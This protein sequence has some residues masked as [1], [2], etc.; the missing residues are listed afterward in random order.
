ML[1]IAITTG[2][3]DG[4]GLEVSAKA[5][6]KIGPQRGICFYLFRHSNSEIRSLRIL[7]KRFKAR[8]FSNWAEAY[9]YKPKN[10]RELVEIVSQTPPAR[11]VETAGKACAL[12][13]LD[14]MVTAPLS[15]QSILAAGLKDIGHTDILKRV[16]GAEIAYMGFIG[17]RFNVVLA[18]DHIPLGAVS[19]SLST[20]ALFGA[21]QAANSLRLRLGPKRRNLP[22][23]LLG[24]NPHASDSGIIGKEESR[25]F[26]EALKLAASANISVL[27]PLVPD[28]AFIKENWGKFSS[29]VACYHD[30]GLIPFKMVHGFNSG[31]HVSLGLPIKRTSVDHGT[32]KDIF[33]QGVAKSGSMEEAILWVLQWVRDELKLGRNVGTDQ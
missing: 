26:V 9:A 4:I 33:G 12:G 23:G 6:A 17:K 27:G 28:A 15:K 5:L 16:S 11:W 22:L 32:A 21:I 3:A 2:D 1:R 30:Q 14:A 25:I 18:T 13:S 19:T 20:A 24:L 29:Y 7:H 31:V 8:V 10:H